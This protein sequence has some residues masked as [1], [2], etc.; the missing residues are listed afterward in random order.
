MLLELHGSTRRDENTV[1]DQLCHVH[2]PY[3]Q[4]RP[5]S[6]RSRI[7]ER[8]IQYGGTLQAALTMSHDARRLRVEG[9][10][11]VSSTVYARAAHRCEKA[12]NE[13]PAPS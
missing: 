7:F 3:L 11:A 5:G 6:E 8:T 9:V 13:L 10:R 4:R 2:K 12:S 1:Q